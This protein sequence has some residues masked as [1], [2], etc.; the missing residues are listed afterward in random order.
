MANRFLCVLFLSVVSLQATEVE[1]YN[2]GLTN[3]LLE[4]TTRDEGTNWESRTLFIAR[5]ATVKIDIVE[6][7][8]ESR[9][10]VTWRYEGSVGDSNK[11]VLD[12]V[13]PYLGSGRPKITL[14][15]VNSYAGGT[16]VYENI[17]AVIGAAGVEERR[18]TE[19]VELGFAFA[20]SVGMLALGAR[21]VRRIIAGG[22]DSE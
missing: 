7:D 6:A 2:G 18:I 8:W 16:N 14:F 12:T 17:M 1:L 5:G 15:G 10:T 21:W 20:F 9:N 13:L 3:S 22:G 11:V 19:G 4:F